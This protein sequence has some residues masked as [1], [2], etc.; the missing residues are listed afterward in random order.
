[1]PEVQPAV[2]QTLHKAEAPAHVPG[3][4]QDGGEEYSK[5]AQFFIKNIF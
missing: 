2:L 5:F 4:Q 3:L 1:M